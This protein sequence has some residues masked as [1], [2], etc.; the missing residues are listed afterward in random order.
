MEQSLQKHAKSCYISMERHI[1]DTHLYVLVDD[2]IVVV[3][4]NME[5]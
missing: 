4:Q 1:A 2:M 3:S 5:L